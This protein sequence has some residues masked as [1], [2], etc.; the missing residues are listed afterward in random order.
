MSL[1][2]QRGNEDVEGQALRAPG[3]EP[4]ESPIELA[5]GSNAFRTGQR[6][7]LWE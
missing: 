1:T 6:V 3:S 4:Q 7:L 2:V 5:I